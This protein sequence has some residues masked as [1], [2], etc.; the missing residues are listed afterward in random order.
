MPTTL[1]E[2]FKDA[3]GFVDKCVAG[4]STLPILTNI[5]MVYN[6]AKG[7]TFQAT[8]L[9][10][11]A[12]V[13]LQCHQMIGDDGFDLA[14]PAKVLKESIGAID[15]TTQVHIS[16][17]KDSLRL[18]AGSLNFR[19]KGL[20]GADFP[21][22]PDVSEAQT[23]VLPLG[24]MVKLFDTVAYAA[25]TDESRPTLTGVEMA[26]KEG[27]ISV[28]GT[29]GYRLAYYC[30]DHTAILA[31]HEATLIVPARS[32]NEFVRVATKAIG[33]SKKGAST[34]GILAIMRNRNQIALSIPVVGER[35]VEGMI[36]SQIIDARFPDYRAIIPKSTNTKITVDAGELERALKTA[37]PFTKDNAGIT[38]LDIV[39]EHDTDYGTLTIRATSAEMGEVEQELKGVVVGGA[40][41]MVFNNKYLMETVAHIDGEE[42]VIELTQSTRPGLFRSATVVNGSNIHVVMPMHPPR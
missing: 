7:I 30:M 23:L 15:K 1:G 19:L 34:D 26:I 22:I 35:L 39:G 36:A 40:I 10:V 14:I 21:L 12:A 41:S 25:S 2:D 38:R 13:T 24:D 27:S 29:D 11:F 4:K 42:I 6:P 9:E 5:R 18:Q 33:E 28:A 37:K 16:A 32:V 20:P 3:V 17:E 31:E 8:N